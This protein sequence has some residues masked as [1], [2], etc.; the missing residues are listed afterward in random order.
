MSTAGSA[1]S[2]LTSDGVLYL[3]TRVDL[4]KV[5]AAELVNEELGGTGVAVVDGLCKLDSVVEDSLADLLV[6]VSGRS[7]FDDLLVT[8]LDGAVTLEQ[9]NDV[10]FAIGKDLD[11]DVTRVVEEACSYQITFSPRI[12][13]R[14]LDED[15]TVAERSLSLRHG[16]LEALLE[17]GLLADNTHPATATAHG[18]LDDDRE[19]V[20][21]DKGRGEVVGCN[22]SGGTGHHR[23]LGL[24][25]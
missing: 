11:L 15:G 23:H 5:V 25:G 6:E 10:A 19:A 9:V 12:W 16:T 3:D 8:P 17:L 14:T 20:L 2:L 4:D 1:K 21:L 22:R 24:H 7:D 13:I 18:G